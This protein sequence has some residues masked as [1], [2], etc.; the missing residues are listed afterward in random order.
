[1]RADDSR[2]APG[3]RADPSRARRPRHAWRRA[4]AGQA[5][6][7]VAAASVHGTAG[8]T[9][10]RVSTGC[11]TPTA[12]SLHP[13]LHSAGPPGRKESASGA[14]R[15]GADA[16]RCVRTTADRRRACGPILRGRDARDTH[17]DVPPPARRAGRNQRA[18]PV[19]SRRRETMRADDS[20]LAPGLRA[21]LS[22]ARRPRH[23]WPPAARRAL[24]CA[25]RVA[26]RMRA[27]CAHGSRAIPKS[28]PNSRH[29]LFPARPA[30]GNAPGAHACRLGAQNRYIAGR[31]EEPPALRGRTSSPWNQ[32]PGTEMSACGFAIHDWTLDASLAFAQAR[33]TRRFLAGETPATHLGEMPAAP[34]PRTLPSLAFAQART[35]RRFLAGET[36]ATHMGETPAAPAPRTLPSLAFAQARTPR[37]F[38][39]GRDARDTPGRDARGTC[40]TDTSLPRFRSGSHDTALP[41]RARRPR[42]T[43][44]RRPRHAWARRPRHLR[45]GHFPPSLSLRLA[46]HGDFL[47]GETPATHMGEMPA[48]HMGEMPAARLGEMPAAQAAIRGGR[49]R[50]YIT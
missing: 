25:A 44:A 5:R 7:L 27:F 50:K 42:H 11:A 39:R 32:E 49:Q 40:A 21:D 16:R 34:A 28:R 23:A 47:A 46:R 13:W 45:H 29:F 48:T 17:G 37:R 33:T 2:L 35:T 38:P 36:P 30:V 20:R 15:F 1:M 8:R 3:L 6:S 18:A 41:S 26:G 24:A 9:I 19:D 12:A 43:W 4:A 14:S 10:A 31:V 22:R